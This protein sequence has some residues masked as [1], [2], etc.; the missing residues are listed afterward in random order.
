MLDD[1]PNGCGL[2][3]DFFEGFEV[4][5]HNARRITQDQFDNAVRT[6][7]TRVLPLNTGRAVMAVAAA[8]GFDISEVR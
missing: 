5:E 4:G 1:C 7:S 6:L 2:K 3:R 8:L